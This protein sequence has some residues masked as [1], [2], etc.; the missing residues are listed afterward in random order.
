MAAFFS[1]LTTT[2]HYL[3]LSC[4]LLL[5]TPN[6]SF[7]Y[8]RINLPHMTFY[9]PH[10]NKHTPTTQS[11]TQSPLKPGQK[12]YHYAPQ[13]SV[14]IHTYPTYYN[15]GLTVYP[16][17]TSNA[18]QHTTQNAVPH[19]PPNPRT[20][21]VKKMFHQGSRLLL[22]PEPPFFEKERGSYLG[23]ISNFITCDVIVLIVSIT[24]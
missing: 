10:T 14:R 3:F 12:L 2:T 16:L 22:I 24:E 17:T 8:N 20:A 15:I 4:Q 1:D 11:P 7:E 23:I 6:Y 9:M 21:L 5:H 18:I 19:Q 13:G